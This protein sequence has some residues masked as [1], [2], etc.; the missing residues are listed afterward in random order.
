MKYFFVSTILFI[1]LHAFSQD[2]TQ[3]LLAQKKGTWKA[4]QQGQIFKVTAADLVKEK[5]IITSIHKMIASHYNPMGCQVSYSTVY[6]ANYPRPDQPWLADTYHYAMYILRYLCDKQSTDKSKYYVDIST[7][8]TVNITANA[9][10]W[11]NSLYAANITP[12]DFRGYLQLTKRPVKKDG[13][14]FMGEEQAGYN[15]TIFEYRWLITYNDTLPF[16]YI[17]RKEY[18]L[19]QRKRLEKYVKDNPGEKAFH[20][21]YF[22]N[23]SDNLTKPEK[24][25]SQPA[26]CMRNDDERFEKFVEEGTKGSFIAV[27][28]NLDY[29]HKK[30]PKSAPQFFTVVYKVSKDNAVFEDNIEAIKKA[31]D[32]AVLK[33]MLDK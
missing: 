28:P 3:E 32:F 23:I 14:Y 33:N 16:S 27:K 1:S 4:N 6:G 24:E 17:S 30:I 22:K 15:S 8:T 29:Y 11:L 2:C 19:I 10:F 25:L 7:P 18:L 5:A 12:D 31:V 21:Q 13:Y 20:E 9:M 26:I